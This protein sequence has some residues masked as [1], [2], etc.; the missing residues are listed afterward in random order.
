MLF[1]SLDEGYA[2]GFIDPAVLDKARIR[3]IIKSRGNEPPHS[4]E[5]ISIVPFPDVPLNPDERLLIERAPYDALNCRIRETGDAA[6]IRQYLKD[7]PRLDPKQVNQFS[8]LADSIKRGDQQGERE[9]GT[10]LATGFTQASS[11]PR[12]NQA[13]P[14]SNIV[15]GPLDDANSLSSVGKSGGE[16]SLQSNSSLGGV[17]RAN[18]F[19]NVVLG[20]LDSASNSQL[21]ARNIK[22]SPTLAARIN[23]IK[24]KIGEI[25][26]YDGKSIS[27]GRGPAS[28]VRILGDTRISESHCLIS[29]KGG[30]LFITDQSS[31]NGTWVNNER[32]KETEEKELSSGDFI[33]LA[34]QAFTIKF[35]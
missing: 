20:P 33:G 18:E 31:T 8:R 30:K 13:N 28:D 23:G 6:L 26:L 4:A 27:I 29:N 32:L 14:F 22:L 5:E 9:E 17:E 3:L 12:G 7:N 24:I 21:L 25:V 2:V 16:D 10:Q 11:L 35:S 1:R 34:G 19:S 15:S